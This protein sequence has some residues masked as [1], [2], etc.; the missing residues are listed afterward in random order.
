V[1]RRGIFT[2]FVLSIFIALLITLRWRRPRPLAPGVE[3]SNSSSNHHS[4]TVARIDLRTASLALYWK[5]RA[6]YPLLNFDRLAKHIA[7]SRLIFATNAGIFSPGYTPLGLH[8]ENG[9]ELVPINLS[10]GS[11]NF[12]MKPNGVFFIDAAG[13]HIVESSLYP[14]TTRETCLATQSGPLLLIRG[15]LNPN[16]RAHS[17]NTHVRS[18]VGVLSPDRVVFVLSN[19][20]VTFHQFA[21]FFRDDLS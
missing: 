14:G 8:V 21:T 5:D 9:H 15:Q 17:S 7:P 18:A 11:G 16:F 13:A 20:P 1:K 4:Y 19:E 2:I 3:L 6:D 10:A 12:Y